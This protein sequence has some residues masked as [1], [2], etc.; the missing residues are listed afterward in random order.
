MKSHIVKEQL[1]TKILEML[2]KQG[3]QNS[4]SKHRKFLIQCIDDLGYIKKREIVPGS[5][6]EEVR[7]VPVGNIAGASSSNYTSPSGGYSGDRTSTDTYGFN[8]TFIDSPD[9][10]LTELQ[11]RG[12]STEESEFNKV[13]ETIETA[14]QKI[15]KKFPDIPFEKIKEH[16]LKMYQQITEYY[17]DNVYSLKSN[18]QT[19]KKGYIALVLWYALIQFNVVLT[20][21]QLVGY[22]NS[23]LVSYLF[24][25]DQ[26]LHRIFTN[27]PKQKNNL[28]GMETTLK[29][30][31]GEQLL[32]KIYEVIEQMGEK[33]TASAVY[34]ICSVPVHKGGVLSQKVSKEI[35]LGFLEKWCKISQRTI[36]NG[37]QEII[38]YFK[39][40]PEHKPV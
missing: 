6:H 2:P 28:C 22:F 35:T 20:R 3:R 34:Y 24:E 40:H 18:S 36:S 5:I 31:I 25:P 26:Y 9:S 15:N 23:V 38:A 19:I 21:E 1:T 4:D 30:I 32:H 7:Y 27:L 39:A 29:E 8:R 16:A 13:A 37:V 12:I 11:K 14:L 17:I 33:Y 10:R